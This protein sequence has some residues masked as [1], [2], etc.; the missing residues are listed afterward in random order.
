MSDYDENPTINNFGFQNASNTLMK[1]YM[2]LTKK[3]ILQVTSNTV[4]N[5]RGWGVQMM[6]TYETKEYSFADITEP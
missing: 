5:T 3:L 1:S 4:I 2:S 6:A